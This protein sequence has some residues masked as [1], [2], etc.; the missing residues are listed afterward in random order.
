MYVNDSTEKI[1]IACD[2]REQLSCYHKGALGNYSTAKG[3]ICKTQKKDIMEI[4]QIVHS[5]V[6]KTLSDRKKL[7]QVL[8]CYIDMD[9][10]LID[11]A[12]ISV[13]GKFE[14][15]AGYFVGSAMFGFKEQNGFS[16]TNL[17]KVDSDHIKEAMF[18]PPASPAVKKIVGVLTVN[19]KMVKCTNE[20][21]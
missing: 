10:G 12:A 20:R 9:L 15:K 1:I 6:K 5:K 19:G 8:S 17:G 2:I 21:V 7:M 13:L 14:S 16:I 4:A 18:I 3:I 11:A